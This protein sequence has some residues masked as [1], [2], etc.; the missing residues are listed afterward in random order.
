MAGALLLATAGC[1]GEEAQPIAARAPSAEIPAQMQVLTASATR[2]MKTSAPPTTDTDESGHK[3][4]EQLT[5]RL[6]IDSPQFSASA[7]AVDIR[8]R[9]AAG[10]F[11]SYSADLCI[12][13]PSTCKAPVFSSLKDATS[14]TGFS[15]TLS[16]EGWPRLAPEVQNAAIREIIYYQWGHRANDASP[17]VVSVTGAT[18]RSPLDL[19]SPHILE[20]F[21][22]FTPRQQQS[23]GL[24]PSAY[25]P[26]CW[27][28]AISAIADKDATYARTKH[29]HSTT[30]ESHR[31]MGAEEFRFHMLQFEEVKVPAP[32]D[33][34][35]YY[36]DDPIYVQKKDIY[37]GEIHAA[38]YLGR[39]EIVGQD[40]K[41]TTQDIV[42]TKN[43]RGVRDLLHIQTVKSLD[44]V[45][46][47]ALNADDP[48]ILRYQG[49]D[50][51]KRR[52]FR[53]KEGAEL[54]DPAVTGARAQ[55][56][57]AYVVDRAN[58]ADRWACS[59]GELQPPLVN[60]KPG[61]CSDFPLRWLTLNVAR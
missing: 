38:V 33:V 16:R 23:G 50:P 12:D 31:F 32:G 55:S 5:S 30:W 19:L 26:N 53:V 6:Y 34:V 51:R 21:M 59:V 18:G 49:K 27:Y 41:K 17:L 39:E 61:T 60:G 35:R 43:G 57:T 13:D 8:G 48:L 58:Y 52:F 3:R 56:H 29:L 4:D 9:I 36:L 11:D 28:S 42:L 2:P 40:G 14:P 46:M 20:R 7:V 1:A 37:A 45:Y 15:V 10:V 44:G 25:G 24:G 47:K 54:L 22:T